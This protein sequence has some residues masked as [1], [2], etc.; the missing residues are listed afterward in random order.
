MKLYIAYTYL[1]RLDLAH[2]AKSCLSVLT[3]RY[4]D[5]AICTNLFT[6]MSQNPLHVYD[7]NPNDSIPF[8]GNDHLCT[9]L[10]LYAF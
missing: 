1:S 4:L 3:Y 2:A 9:C 7:Y 10:Q 5:L 6:L 8:S